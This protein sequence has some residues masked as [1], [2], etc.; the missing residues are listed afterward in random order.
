LGTEK[1]IGKVLMDENFFG[2]RQNVSFIINSIPPCCTDE[3]DLKRPSNPTESDRLSKPA[4]RSR[5]NIGESISSRV[6]TTS[7]HNSIEDVRRIICCF[8]EKGI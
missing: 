4:D 1:T 8:L 2:K 6:G 3:F 5:I 7:I